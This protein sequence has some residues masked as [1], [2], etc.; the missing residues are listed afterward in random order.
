ML[1]PISLAFLDI[2]THALTE[3]DNRFRSTYIFLEHF[4]SR[5][6]GGRPYAVSFYANHWY[7]NSRPH[8]GRPTAEGLR[9]G[10]QYFNSRP[11]GG[12]RESGNPLSFFEGDFNSRPHGG[13]RA[14]EKG[15]DRLSYFN[16]RPHGGR[17]YH[18][19]HGRNQEIFQLTPSRRATQS[20]RHH[21]RMVHI[22]THALTEGDCSLKTPDRE[23]GRFQL[24]PSRRATS[25]YISANASINIS[26]HALTEGDLILPGF[27]QLFLSISTHALTE[28]DLAKG[29]LF[30]VQLYFNSRPHGGRRQI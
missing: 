7:F 10:T 16:S 3:G 21:F 20:H 25:G 2:S 26:T 4:N 5:P 19:H 14:R 12:R 6:H 11:H 1:A 27:L 29:R 18:T 15:A 17:R 24:T 8:G 23:P 22:S 28:G 9:G 30:A 13:R